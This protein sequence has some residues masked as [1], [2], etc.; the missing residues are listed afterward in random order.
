MFTEQ[1]DEK[2]FERVSKTAMLKNALKLEPSNTNTN[3]ILSK[4]E[5]S[6]LKL[7]LAEEKEQ[8]MNKLDS[9]LSDT[10]KLMKELSLTYEKNEELVNRNTVLEQNFKKVNSTNKKL[11]ETLQEKDVDIENFIQV[12]NQYCKEL[13]EI[14]KTNK[15]LHNIIRHKSDNLTELSN[16]YYVMQF[17]LFSI[18]I[19]FISYIVLH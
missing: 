19:I 9:E 15:N 11:E 14:E 13:D 4:L 10:H 16:K 5:R 3:D 8:Y 2:E 18:I 17:Y 6:R 12:N 7:K 1:V